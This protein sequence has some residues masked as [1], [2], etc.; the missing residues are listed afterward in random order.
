MEIRTGVT[1][2]ILVQ[3]IVSPSPHFGIEAALY[4]V[5]GSDSERFCQT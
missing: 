2:H 1:T 3:R 5:T 4:R